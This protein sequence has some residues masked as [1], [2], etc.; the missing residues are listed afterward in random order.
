MRL[1][2]ITLKYMNKM[3][4]LKMKKILTF[5]LI[6]SIALSTSTAY[7]DSEIQAYV[8]ISNTVIST[9]SNKT[10]PSIFVKDEDT[11]KAVSLNAK[12]IDHKLLIPLSEILRE[13]DY[14]VTWHPE[15]Q[16]ID[17][18][19]G[20]HFTQVTIGKNSYYKHKMAPKPLSAAPTII[21]NSTYVPVEFFTDILDLGIHSKDNEITI[22]ESMMAIYSGLIKEIEYNDEK[23][24]I[25]SITLSDDIESEDINQLTLVHLSPS[26]T[27]LQTNLVVGKRITVISPPIM[28]LSI[29]AQVSA[30]VIY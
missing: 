23:T 25:I 28:T 26:T 19:K 24:D 30:Y 21:N 3:E 6:G 15:T 27:S 22:S 4:A 12:E 7:A 18:S 1:M 17:I 8:P 29:P 11:L 13:L 20:V 16:T 9:T 5:M 2:Y 10:L 14:Q